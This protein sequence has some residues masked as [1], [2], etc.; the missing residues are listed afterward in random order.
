[1]SELI[2]A[3]AKR[4]NIRWQ[5]MAG[6]CALALLTAIPPDGAALASEKD[7][8]V[9]WIELGGQFARM[10]DGQDRF[11]APFENGPGPLHPE[12]FPAFPPYGYTLQHPGLVPFDSAH[13]FNLQKPPIYSI[14]G[15]GK[16][17]FTPHGTD[18]SLSVSVRYG[19]ATGH[20][21]EITKTPGRPEFVYWSSGVSDF[22]LRYPNFVRF[23]NTDIDYKESHLVLDFQAGKDIGLG[24]FGGQSLI[25]AGV[26]IAQFASR[27][28]VNIFEDPRFQAY[29]S[30]GKYRIPPGKTHGDTS[31]K[32]K[33][34][35]QSYHFS[36]QS[37]RSFHG[38]GPTVS[39]SGS[40][41]FAGNPDAGEVTFDWGVNGA[42]L[43]GRQKAE[44]DH[45]TSSYDRYL[46]ILYKVAPRFLQYHND[47]PRSVREHSVVVPNLG[48]FAGL[49]Y[50]FPN[51]KVSVGYRADFFFG[52][53]D[54]GIDA[55][56]TEDM[57][58]HGPFAKV[59]I[60]LGG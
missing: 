7:T 5:L 18:W 4:A 14:S 11:T 9:I 59:S 32:Y 42:V 24:M 57:A 8:P 29:R 27:S 15:E 58:F 41:P 26:R 3:S 55:R 38:I 1:M 30:A 2:E 16:V 23:S 52:A 37:R 33:T 49:S 47:P 20:R 10:S 51:A 40:T 36:G 34:R 28:S 44:T 50:K 46:M 13:P 45:Q 12:A 6:A 19:R 25:E 21:S 54:A 48:G 56:H 39:W 43:F 17:R 31:F 35:F 22:Q 60:G 53:M